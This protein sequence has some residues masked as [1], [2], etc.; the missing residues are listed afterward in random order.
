MAVDDQTEVIFFRSLKGR[1]RDN[2]FLL[3]FCTEL[4]GDVHLMAVHTRDEFLIFGDIWQMSQEHTREVVHCGLF[5]A[6][7]SSAWREVATGLAGWASF[8]LCIL[9]I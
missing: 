1:C 2:Q 3:A 9:A 7:S 8:E 5:S 6:G 4:S